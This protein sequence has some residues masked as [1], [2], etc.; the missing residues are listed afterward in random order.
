MFLHERLGDLGQEDL[1]AM[2]GIPKTGAAADGRPEVVS[3]TIL[4]RAGVEPHPDAQWSGS[5]P[6]FLTK[7]LLQHAGCPDGVRGMGEDSEETI[8]LP[9]S[10]D[11]GAILL[12]DAFHKECFLA[13]KGEL[14]RLGLPLPHPGAGLHIGEEK[15]YSLLAA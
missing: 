10:V 1:P 12:P 8:P 13:G 15:R 7:P 6:W 14:H 9:A 5:R 11:D 2:R 3:I 4:G